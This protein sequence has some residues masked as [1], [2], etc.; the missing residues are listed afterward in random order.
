ML[1]RQK[2]VTVTNLRSKIDY[3]IIVSSEIFHFKSSLNGRMKDEN[4][5]TGLIEV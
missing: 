1:N 5:G 3:E 2:L 4:I